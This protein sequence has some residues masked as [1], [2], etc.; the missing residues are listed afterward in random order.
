M[1]IVLTLLAHFS[2]W[3]F[4]MDLN[5]YILIRARKARAVIEGRDGG[6]GRREREDSFPPMAK[7]TNAQKEME[8]DSAGLIRLK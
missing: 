5:T 6:G 2:I 8:S 7:E 1:H 3:L 4:Q